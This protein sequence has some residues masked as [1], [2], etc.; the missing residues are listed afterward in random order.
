MTEDT[1]TTIGD[2]EALLIKATGPEWNRRI[3]S[4][5]DAEEWRQIHYDD[6]ETILDRVAT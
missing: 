2:F 3:M 6:R 5:N 4:F 1:S